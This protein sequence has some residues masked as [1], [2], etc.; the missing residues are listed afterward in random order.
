MNLILHNHLNWQSN[1]FNNYILPRLGIGVNRWNI[2]KKNYSFLTNL[3]SFFCYLN[4]SIGHQCFQFSANHF[5]TWNRF[6]SSVSSSSR[7]QWWRPS[8][9]SRPF[10]PRFRSA[11][12]RSRTTTRRSKP[13]S[14]SASEVEKE[15]STASRPSPVWR[16][17][18]LPK[19]FFLFNLS[20]LSFFRT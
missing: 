4:T 14:R 13:R 19:T 9:L 7:P 15:S 8:T 20:F 1:V 5:Q 2:F 11:S 10:L 18:S 3:E 12:S 16:I 17:A 6:S